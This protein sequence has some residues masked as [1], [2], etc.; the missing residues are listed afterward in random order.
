LGGVWQTAVILRLWQEQVEGLT[1][2]QVHR[3]EGYRTVTVGVTV[4]WRPAL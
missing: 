4:F 2:W 3:H 1:G